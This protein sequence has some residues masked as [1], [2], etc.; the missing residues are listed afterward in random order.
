MTQSGT[1][2]PLC[3]FFFF[4]FFRPRPNRKGNGAGGGGENPKLRRSSFQLGGDIFSGAKTEVGQTERGGTIGK[5]GRTFKMG[6]GERGRGAK[7]EEI[8]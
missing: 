6:T 1:I 5:L 7:A 3:L 8:T 4:L 2:I